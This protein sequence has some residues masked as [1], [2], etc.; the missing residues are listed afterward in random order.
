MYVS[1]SGLCVVQNTRLRPVNRARY[2]ACSVQAVDRSAD[3]H[4][5]SLVTGVNPFPP[6]TC[7]QFVRFVLSLL[8]FPFSVRSARV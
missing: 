7:F 6:L 8:Y 3:F 1:V 4:A 2:M 5:P